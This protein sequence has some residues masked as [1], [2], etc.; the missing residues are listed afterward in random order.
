[1]V[2]SPSFHNRT[3]ELAA[4]RRAVASGRPEL[5]IVCGRRGAGKS[6]LLAEAFAGQR[7][8]WYEATL[9]VLNDQLEDLAAALR[10][11][12]P[13]AVIGRLASVGQVLEALA[14]L[15]EAAPE[16]VAIWVIDELPWLDR[17]APGV[18]TVIKEWWDR[19]V[20]GRLSN[21]KLFLAG[22]IESWMRA[23]T[24]DEGGP[25][26]NRRTRQLQVGPM[27]YLDA[28]LFYPAYPAVQKIETFAV[29]GGLPGYLAEIRPERD[30]WA[31][32]ADLMLDPTARL[33]AEPEW[34]R[35]GD[36]RGDA[37][38]ASILRAI[39]SGARQPSEIARAIGRH[40]ASEVV[41]QLDRLCE[42]GL[43]EREVPI[44]EREASR[45]RRAR[46]RL[47]DHYV[48]F[49]YRYVDRLRHLI[50]SYRPNVALAEIRGTFD[51]YVSSPA[52]EDVCRQFV[53]LAAVRGRLPEELAAGVVGSWWTARASGAGNGGEAEAG[54][55]K[56]DEI[57]VVMLREGRTVLVGEC[58]WSA[59]P[60]DMRT[61]SGLTATLRRGHAEL[62]PVDRPW[63]ALFSRSGFHPA[64]QQL[65]KD[66]QERLLLVT[67]DDLFDLA[68]ESTDC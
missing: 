16:Q 59:A 4:I 20:R 24:M 8:F 56:G 63:R 48:A 68:P 40:S 62:R 53:H 49:W 38:Y 43:V 23:Q 19:R 67:P 46:Y 11:Y 60:V 36:L 21:A 2:V 54:A 35:Y 10:T 15:A 55:G 13:H 18:A 25:L 28:S 22:S 64:L 27:S 51:R 30:L 32:V 17:A 34:Y 39:A 58:K 7:I 57:D 47:S 52:F 29:F 9:R 44:H 14:D 50:A 42:L 41:F 66:P 26:H 6:R 37:V 45:S 12:A 1:M 5:V 31:N 65:A 3:A 33:A 61:L